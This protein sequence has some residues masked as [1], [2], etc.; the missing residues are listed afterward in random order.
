MIIGVLTAQVAIDGADSL[1]EK[2]QV[3]K[4]LLAHLRREFNISVAEVGD[5]EIWRSA[6]IGIAHVGND[7]AFA[8]AVLDKVVDHIEGDP[9]VALGH[10]E[11]ELL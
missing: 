11:T 1:K 10:Y 8:H 3:L 4:S 9:R 6:V 7:S 5:Q 2:R